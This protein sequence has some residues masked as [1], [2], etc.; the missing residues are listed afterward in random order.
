M[1]KQEEIRR[2]RERLLELGQPIII[3]S[4]ELPQPE[5]TGDPPPR[6]IT[7]RSFVVPKE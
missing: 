1:T 7:I 5:N 6:D 3:P 4:N 2:P